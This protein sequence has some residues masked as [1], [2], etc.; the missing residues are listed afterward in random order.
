MEADTGRRTEPRNVRALTG[1]RGAA[2]L[3][4]LAFHYGAPL[5][6]ALG[7][8]V[9]LERVREGGYVWV[10]FFLFLSGFLLGRANSTPMERV[11]RRRFWIARAARLYP[12]YLL[13]FVLATPFALERW[14]H[15]GTIGA[16]K[17]AVVALNSLLL[18]N[19]WTPSIARLWNAPGWCASVVAAFY[20]MFPF[21]ASR[22]SRL[23]RRGLAVA[24]LAFWASSLAFPLAWMWFMPDGAVTPSHLTWGEPQ[25]LEALKFHPLPRAGEFAAGVALGL[26][27]ARGE[28]SLPRGAVPLA[29]AAVLA[30]LSWGGA[31]YPLVHNGLAVP[32]FAVIVVGLAKEES[33]VT[34]TLA[35]PP[36]FALGEAS[37]AL[38]ALQEPLWR[39]LRAMPFSSAEPSPV[40]VF[41]FC[42]SVCAFSV[43]VTRRLETPARRALRSFLS[44][45]LEERP[46]SEAPARAGGL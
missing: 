37:F 15:G 14:S 6:R 40:F 36:I 28:V 34:R 11:A 35:S 18:L 1:A 45:A 44:R 27:H 10:G 31:P 9:C 43:L 30:L 25:W 38:Y 8:P 21:L 29:L 24:A 19:A 26:M 2:A 7:L 12:A 16:W 32:L 41:S 33:L 5:S 42:V 20:A 39:L 4:I 22:L 46:A 17:A 3:A 13:A 23:S